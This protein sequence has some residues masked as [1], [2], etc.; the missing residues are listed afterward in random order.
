MD[1][2][3]EIT[4]FLEPHCVDYVGF[5]NLDSCRDE[6]ERFGGPVVRKYKHGISIGIAIP[7]SIVD[8]LPQRDDPNVACEYKTHGYDVLNVRLNGVASLLS[9]YLNSKGFKT[10]PVAAAERTNES[11]AAATVSHKMIA[12]QAGLG[13]I[14]KSCLLI[15]ARHGPR[16]R[17]VSLLT[18]APLTACGA[19][20][21]P[22][23]GSYRA[24]AEACPAGAIHG[25]D[26]LPGEAREERFDFEKCQAYFDA[27]KKERKYAVCGMCLFACPY[28]SHAAVTSTDP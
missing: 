11:N 17:F 10:L 15:T 28:G 27:L 13:W 26:F 5:A 18:D 23:C 20:L 21:A 4:A 8:L 7:D 16:A 22:R 25:V 24:C 12:R 9:S 3:R 1:C 2:N 14:G 6:L 19:P